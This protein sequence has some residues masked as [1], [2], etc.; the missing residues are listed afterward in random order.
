MAENKRLSY[1]EIPNMEEDWGLDPRNGMKYS[2]KSVQSFLKKVLNEKS[3]PSW[4]D[5]STNSIHY[6]ADEEAKM[7]YLDTGDVSKIQSTTVL[8]FSGTIRQVKVVNLMNTTS[9]YFTTVAQKAELTCGFISQQKGITDTTWDEV[10]EDFIV[11][12][13][14]DKGSVGNY[15][16]VETD[17]R[18]L[19]GQTLTVDVKK[20]LGS[21]NNRVRFSVRGETTG[22]TSQLVFSVT[23]TAMYLSPSNLN[24]WSPFVEGV[25]YSLGGFHI[26]GT[27]N[28][29]VKVRVSNTEKG[30][31][32]TFEQNIGM[33]TYITNAYL[34]SGLPFP[35]A[36][37]GTYRVE[38]WVEADALQTE[39][40][41]YQIMMI[42]ADEVGTAE[43]VCINEV[44]SD[45]KNGM[46][47]TLFRY[48]VY[49]GGALD[50]RVN[51][52]LSVNGEAHLNQELTG[53]PTGTAQT[54]SAALEIE[55]EEMEFGLTATMSVGSVSESVTMAVDNSLSFPAVAGAVFYMNP[56]TRSNAQE[57]RADIVN[58]ANGQTITA[59]V[60]GIGWVDGTD[61]WTNDEDGR[62]CLLIPAGGRIEMNY[63]P[64]STIGDGW[65]VE[66]SYKIKN[67]AD[68]DEVAAMIASSATDAGFRGVRVKPKNVCV[69]S[70][71][72]NTNDLAQ[73]YNTED[74]ELV[75]LIVSITKNYNTNYGNLVQ[76]FVN[77]G[78]KVSFSFTNT[79]SFVNVGNL[80]LG[81]MSADTYIYKL[82]VYRQGFGWPD[83]ISNWINCL[84]TYEAK[85]AAWTRVNEILD[86]SYHVDFDKVV[87]AGRNT[88]VIEM[89]NG[90]SLPDKLHPSSGECNVKFDVKNIPDG[91]I[92]E[93][94]RLLLTGYE[95][96]LQII[97]GQGTTA[98]TYLRWNLRWKLTKLILKKRRITA[99]KNVASSMHSHK[100][101]ATRLFNMLH[102]IVVGGNEAGARVAVA[103]YP[104][105]GFL[106]KLVDGTTDQYTYDFI[107]LYSVGPDKGDKATFGYDD[108]RFENSVCHLEGTDHTPM[109]VGYDYPWDQCRY[110]AAKEALGAIT[111]SGDISAAWECGA[112]GQL[113]PDETA[114]EAAVQAF[115]D[116]EFRPAYDVIYN[117]RTSILGVSET[118]EQLNSNP[119]EWRKQ[120][121]AEGKPYSELEFWTDGEYD[122]LYYN[123]AESKYKKNGINLLTQFGLSAS[124]VS[125]MTLAEKDAFFKQK[126]REA[127]IAN[128]G[129]Y[130]HIDD[131]LFHETFLEI[132][133]ATDNFKKN[134]YPYKFQLL[135]DGG[136]WRRRQDD[137]DSIADINNQGF[138]AK[139]YSVMLWDKTSSGSVFRGEDS[140]F[141]ILVDECCKEEKK[142]MAR[143]IFD[144]MA[145]SSPYGESK[146]EKL[147]GC[148]RMCFWD[149]AQG[150]F[151]ESAYNADAVWT[152]IDAW[153]LWTSK[154]YDNDV[155]PLQ[156]SLGSHYE[157]ERVW[158]TLRMIFYA[159]MVNWGPFAA[160]SGDD[161]SLG[162]ISF[163][164]VS[165]NTFDVTPAIDMNP[166]ILVGQSDMATAG[167]RVMAGETVKVVIPDMGSKDT[168]IYLQA[169]DYIQDLGDLCNLQVSDANPV[170][171]VGS[172]R[173]SRLKIGDAEAS[174]VTTN[175]KYLTMGA[176]PSMEVVD[177]RNV[178]LQENVDLTQLPRLREALFEGTSVKNVVIA[179]GS[180]VNTLSLP[181][182]LTTLSLVRLQNLTA[183]GLTFG[184]LNSLEMLRVE[185]NAHLDGMALLR[186]AMAGGSLSAVRVLGISGE[187]TAND[188]AL[189]GALVDSGAH[190]ITA[191]GEVDY[192]SGPI[193]E[194]ELT[195]MVTVD[196]ELLDKV[197]EA[198]PNLN[199]IAQGIAKI[200]FEDPEVERII[201]ENFGSDGFI[202]YEQ[203]RE[204]TEFPA[205]LFENNNLI[206]S[207]NELEYFSNL[208]LIR[209]E[210]FF[211]C[212]NLKSVKIPESVNSFGQ[213]VFKNCSNLIIENLFLPN[214]N[215]MSMGSVFCN[216]RVKKVSSLGT[217]KIIGNR[218]FLDCKELTEC[219]IP[220]TVTDM[221]G[222]GI[223]Q[224]ADLRRVTVPKNVTKINY[225]VFQ[226]N[227]NLEYIIFEPTTPPTIDSGN[228]TISSASCIFYVPDE[229]VEAYKTAT[230][231]VG[232]A[233]RIK[234]MSEFA[235]DF[236]NETID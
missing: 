167:R 4:F 199:V 101:G 90:A 72:L 43:A 227:K 133:A 8:N 159:S 200:K 89:L 179:A 18:V 210:V 27:L 94:M 232:N 87:A 34:F 48:S 221:S 26:G 183:E 202:T 171:S 150:Y 166:T 62:P 118:L 234:P 153:P 161:T 86:D 116:T 163:R 192:T 213:A 99:K 6:F 169:T 17:R 154:I 149:Y 29:T 35:S 134:N 56:A 144:A 106:K 220:D 226:G 19:N 92:D 229:S 176:C 233:S 63:A 191:T 131:A 136:K 223:F 2:G 103:Q 152:Y 83:G 112:A 198:L 9:L 69:H 219:I 97:E 126:R 224:N 148:I 111:A 102:L 139:S 129:N 107:G 143:R 76:I 31:D 44:N 205:G 208:E 1:N 10:N 218:C 135:K 190:G 157:A 216:T 11:S 108:P 215:G 140:V 204:V 23:L 30:Y 188:L 165:S 194:G 196:Q 137:L 57:N 33:A 123:I 146:I 160:D 91:E 203:A 110:S 113:A 54:Y 132:I 36:G 178:G 74:E 151:A 24:W 155:N 156:Q 52:T 77:G 38:V 212:D 95:I 231:W 7:A 37:T 138:A 195:I 84:P 122:I 45:V 20:Y 39:H 22:E 75:H 98:M 14:V 172:K 117:N 51:V 211:N 58:E 40:L 114:D 60:S 71:D 189:L 5:P 42:A 214:L 168:H 66:M 217:I 67:A 145:A 93:E 222:Y 105:Y 12:V 59:N 73:S 32:E 65:A 180:K 128:W 81:S 170:L 162:Q 197:R 225:V 25:D 47:S 100:M 124:A 28:K 120:T 16:A 228:L 109:M 187:G 235:T 3:G 88:M 142:A 82:R 182:T 175:V 115:L 236:P 185:G 119:S 104:V 55:S 201:V 61:G 186:S 230:N 80:I 193:I 49:N 50:S 147:V 70:R 41:T 207:F 184:S 173:M 78:A 79:D 46:D 181:G 96:L 85:M 141:T 121:T 64:M 130:W 21:G 127:F 164:A 206:T 68:Y 158:F 174:K 209:N 125:G 15:V 177:A 53:V 13:A